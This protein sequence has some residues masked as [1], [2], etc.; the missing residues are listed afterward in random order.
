M[1]SGIPS[2]VFFWLKGMSTVM[3]R[4]CG[5]F[6]VCPHMNDIDD[7]LCDHVLCTVCVFFY[8]SESCNRQP[9]RSSCWLVPTWLNPRSTSWRWPNTSKQLR[10]SEHEVGISLF[11]SNKTGAKLNLHCCLSLSMIGLEFHSC[12]SPALI[13]Q[14]VHHQNRSVVLVL[15]KV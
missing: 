7:N 9:N 1:Y 12:S 10:P 4:V 5:S 6:F 11:F 2:N 15:K 3:Y 13:K 8:Q 14:T